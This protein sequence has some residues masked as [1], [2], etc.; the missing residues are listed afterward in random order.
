MESNFESNF[1]TLLEFLD[2][3][4]RLEIN[5]LCMKKSVAPGEIIYN[6]GDPANGIFIVASGVV[7]AVTVSPDGLQT[8]TL[9]VMSRG[10][11]FGDLAVLTGQPRLAAVRALEPCELL[12]IEKP[13]FLNLLERIP[14]MG[15]Y[16][17]RN[18]ARRLHKTS[19][20]AHLSVFG[21]DLAGNL[22]H[23]D[24]LTI[25]QAITSMRRTGEL[26]IKN[27]SNELIGDF[28]FREGAAVQ[29]RFAHLEGVE[30]I[31]EGFVQSCTDGSFIFHARE[32]PAVVAA[33]QHRI[34]HN[35]TDLL[36]QGCTRRDAYHALPDSLRAME[37]RLGRLTPE[38][39]W[40]ESGSQALAERIWELMARRPQPLASMWRRLNFSTL[41]FLEV[42]SGL[43]TTGQ[44]E[45]LETPAPENV[46]ET[47]RLPS[48]PNP[49]KPKP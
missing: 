41:S 46:V 12:R 4:S 8:R 20:E 2:A 1:F 39:T 30:A 10:D 13:A 48:P 45:W 15:A 44:A 33:E 11:F 35:S 3:N 24:L 32:Q 6:Q 18:L 31:W 36:I 37:G 43:I 14:K 22:R 42:V 34:E 40:T 21:L 26:E 49:N 19:T 25:F 7:E 28:F 38:L 47:T 17:T 9:G 27:S 23:F 29:A 16:F 5:G